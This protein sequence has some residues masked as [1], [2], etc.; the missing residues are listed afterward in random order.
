MPF[1]QGFA[2]VIKKFPQARFREETKVLRDPEIK[3]VVDPVQ[4]AGKPLLIFLLGA[5]NTG[6]TTWARWACNRAQIA[7]RSLSMVA[8]DPGTSAYDPEKSS[9]G[10]WFQ[11]VQVPNSKNVA[12][13]L[14]SGLQ[15]YCE[16][17]HPMLIDFG[18]NG[19]VPLYSLLRGDPDFVRRIEDSDVG[20]VCIHFLSP[21]VEQELSTAWH[22]RY[23]GLRPSASMVV[24]NCGVIQDRS[25]DPNDAFLPITGH[26]D[27][28]DMLNE[29]VF[30]LFM[31]A[32]DA[33]TYDLITLRRIHFIEAGEGK[34][35]DDGKPPLLGGMDAARVRHW[36]K[37][38]EDVH[39][40]VS[41]WLP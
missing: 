18:G 11:G 27:F 10:R 28:L 2:D 24:L 7:G 4:L 32:L 19:H 17:P 39:D 1:G 6:K 20:L 33:D 12:S 29:G 36:L 8:L 3:P 16:S 31:P 38:M 14:A 37:R 35:S 23:Y 25:R 15:G 30:P 40:P 22:L 21:R 41:S 26:P 9:L 5:G 34:P 13:Y